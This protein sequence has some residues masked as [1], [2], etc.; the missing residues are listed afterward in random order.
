MDVAQAK[1]LLAKLALAKKENDKDDIAEANKEIEAFKNEHPG[2]IDD[3]K[4]EATPAP[5][6]KVEANVV[7]TPESKAEAFKKKAMADFEAKKTEVGKS[8]ATKQSFLE[9]NMTLC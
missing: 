4:A 2:L 6:K 1:M 3:V 5:V 8:D 9:K 7:E